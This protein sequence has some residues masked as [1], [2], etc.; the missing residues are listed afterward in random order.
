MKKPL[1]M[2]LIRK[3]SATRRRHCRCIG[4]TSPTYAIAS[5]EYRI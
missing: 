3:I 2:T 5:G 4:K 1:W